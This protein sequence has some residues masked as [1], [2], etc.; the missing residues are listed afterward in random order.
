MRLLLIVLM[1]AGLLAL[2]CAG[3]GGDSAADE[4]EIKEVIRAYYSAY[5]AEDYATCLGYCTDYGD[6]SD[7]LQVI[8][9]VKGLVGETTVVS[10]KDVKVTGST[11]NAEV[12]VSCGGATDTTTMSLRK[13]GAWKIVFEDIGESDQGNNG[14]GEDGP[15]DTTPP[16]ISQVTVSSVT[17]T[18]AVIAWTTDEPATTKVEYGATAAYGSSSIMDSSLLT[19]HT[20]TITGLAAET[21]YHYRVKSKDGAGNESVSGDD[22]FT[23]GAAVEI[24]SHSSRLD[25]GWYYVVGEVQNISSYNLEY[26]ELTG[27]FYN[28]SGTVI[29]TDFTFTDM[30]TLVPGQKSPFEIILMDSTVASAVDDYVIVNSDYAITS[31][32]PYGGL[33]VL[34]HS[35]N[36]DAYGWYNVVGEVKNV[37]TQSA[38]YVQVIA[39]FYNSA[40]TVIGTE[41]TFTS[42]SDLAADQTAPF[43]M[44]VLDTTVS[45][46]IAS[47]ELQVQC[48]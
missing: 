24:L 41:F 47:Y 4:A 6:E 37:G 40:G 39:T 45:A 22:T 42:P 21:T 32:A 8:A 5:N 19:T 7:A 31:E 23:T 14:N 30:D 27:T 3:N 13:V 18:S 33:S 29:D 26:V 48:L 35:S 16:V 17:L 38:E 34:S 1:A 25:E 20:V 10:I 11:A 9:W 15:D 46:Q 36:L 43:E 12:T 44:T 2:S 28:S